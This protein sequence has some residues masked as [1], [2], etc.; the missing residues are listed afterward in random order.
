MKKK[1]EKD[2]SL[3]R[4]KIAESS[5]YA[6]TKFYLA[7]HISIMPSEA[8]LEIYDMLYAITNDRGKKVAI[9][10]PRDFGKSTMIT[11]AYII[12]LICYA[13]E[14]FIVVISNTASQ[15]E[16]ILDN[17]RSELTENE[18]LLKD[19]PEIFEADG[20]PK[21]PRWK[22]NDIIT[23]NN[24]EILALGYGQQIR[25]RKHRNYRPS[26]IILDDLEDGENTFSSDAKEKMQKWLEGSVLK[27]GSNASNFLFIGT[28]HNSFSLLGEYTNSEKQ[29]AWKGER[30]KA[31][32][33]FPKNMNLWEKCWKI[34][35]GKELYNGA[36]GQPA[37]MQYYQ[38]NKAAMDEG[39][40]IL[41]PQKWDLYKLMDMYYD[42]IFSFNSEMQ[43]DPVDTDK[44]T[45]NV[46]N[47]TYWSD[48]YASVDVL[49]R[50]LG[51]EVNFYGA[52]DPALEGGDYSAI[53][54][55]A[56]HKGDYYV[57]VS[58]ITHNDQDKLIKDI[59][60]YAKRYRFSDF[61]VEA[62][63]FQELLVK[64]LEKEAAKE[65]IPIVLTPIKNSGRKQNRIME[66]YAWI[67]NGSI[68]FCKSDKLLLDQFRGFPR[69]KHDDGPDA[70]EMAMR[71]CCGQYEDGT[72]ISYVDK[73]DIYPTIKHFEG[74]NTDDREF[75]GFDDM[76]D[77][78]PSSNAVEVPV[79]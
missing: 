21:P 75:L 30:Y 23:R 2:V 5:L 29:P 58:D 63:N 48:Q 79:L 52:C 66:L 33:E 65:E 13:K 7:K 27:A 72:G 76:D 45:F 43:N 8:H 56:K 31:M 12:Y 46:D 49:L 61:I 42:N 60:A 71:A 54:V 14:Q 28:V 73:K 68:K 34:R 67:K 40:V 59:L 22:E 9:A 74:W 47:F 20:K 32:I 53:I 44:M 4:R 15:A 36:K 10:A 64:A 78:G 1:I 3:T 26:L 70:L 77:D 51:D 25:G 62:N 50:D 17:V 16:K 18:L 11:L 38:D 57:V 6:F 19:F 41:W 24:I 69:G 37:A 35:I 39:A 55:L